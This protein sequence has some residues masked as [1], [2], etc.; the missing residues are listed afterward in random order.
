MVE[1][2]H[3]GESA[4]RMS[5]PETSM[6][7]KNDSPAR[8]NNIRLARKVGAIKP[9]SISHS[10]ERSAHGQLGCRIPGPYPRHVGAALGINSGQSDHERLL[11]ASIGSLLGR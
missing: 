6:N 9:K 5:M 1:V 2:G 7:Q 8:K 11:C 4:A 3:I 10:V